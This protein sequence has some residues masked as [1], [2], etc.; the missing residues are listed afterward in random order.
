M[1]CRD[2][3]ALMA[4]PSTDPT[5]D[6]AIADHIATCPMC[7]DELSDG[8]I[9]RFKS[10]SAIPP[11]NLTSRIMAQLP[12]TPALARV[13]EE[14]KQQRRRF[15]AT[16]LLLAILLVVGI[17][18]YGIFFNSSMPATLFGGVDSVVGRGVL[19]LTLAGKPMVASFSVLGLPMLMVLGLLL[20]IAVVAWKRLA[21]PTAALLTEVER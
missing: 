12:A 6:Q 2:V 19:A 18:A 15:I 17:G 4:Q 9:R 10:N 3:R 1:N 14:R 7:A 5:T 20:V 11:P 21:R 16:G 8:T 13:Q